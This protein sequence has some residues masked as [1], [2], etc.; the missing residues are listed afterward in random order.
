MGDVCFHPGGG[1]PPVLPAIASLLSVVRIRGFFSFDNKPLCP[2]LDVS[3]LTGI[4]V[5]DGETVSQSFSIFRNAFV[6]KFL[7]TSYKNRHFVNLLP[8][9]SLTSPANSAIRAS[10]RG[11]SIASVRPSKISIHL[12]GTINIAW[13]SS[14]SKTSFNRKPGVLTMHRM[15]RVKSFQPP[16]GFGF[17]N[18]YGSQGSP[19]PILTGKRQGF[20]CK[21]RNLCFVLAAIGSPS[22]LRSTCSCADIIQSM[23]EFLTG[24]TRPACT[25]AGRRAVRLGVACSLARKS[26]DLQVFRGRRPSSN[27]LESL[28]C[29]RP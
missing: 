14:S 13:I 19:W 12:V 8:L 25:A 5:F 22:P 17:R 26:C 6:I 10:R 7:F 15:K 16:C 27:N 20:F 21:P 28:V 4:T 2:R 18:F 29:E 3:K 9:S 24:C 1:F 11:G 23:C